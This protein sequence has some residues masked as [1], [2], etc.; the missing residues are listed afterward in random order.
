MNPPP[1]PA[2]V[3]ALPRLESQGPGPGKLP[4]FRHNPRRHPS[5]TAGSQG[6]Q[7][8]AILPRFPAT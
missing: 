8:C 3:A 6:S 4:E 1:I 2:K 5:G 7:L